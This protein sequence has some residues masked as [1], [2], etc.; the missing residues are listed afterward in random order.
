MVILIT[1]TIVSVVS[2]P[3]TVILVILIAITIVSVVSI[4][5]TGVPLVLLIITS[6]SIVAS[7]SHISISISCMSSLAHFGRMDKAAI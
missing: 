6:I 7:I 4:P 1:I 3:I 2:I 5:I